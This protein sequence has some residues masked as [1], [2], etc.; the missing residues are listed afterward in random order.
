MQLSV[1]VCVCVHVHA[2]NGELTKM[3][4]KDNCFLMADDR[5][6]LYIHVHIIKFLN[7]LRR[8]L[9]KTRDFFVSFVCS[10]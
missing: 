4:E 1:C 9:Y 5:T 6:L 3:N 8:D 2:C 10:M 7:H